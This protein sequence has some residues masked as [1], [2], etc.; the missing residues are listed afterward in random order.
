MNVWLP[1]ETVKTA[2]PT[3]T[4]PGSAAVKMDTGWRMM[5]KAAQVGGTLACS[6]LTSSTR[7][8]ITARLLEYTKTVSA[9]R[10]KEVS[11]SVNTYGVRVIF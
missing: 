4:V 9:Y 2:V 10:V 6:K 11:R 5:A 1:M 8:P 3:L 7:L